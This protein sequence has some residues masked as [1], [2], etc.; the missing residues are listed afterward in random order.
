MYLID[1]VEGSQNL[2]II[3]DESNK[4]YF[5]NALPKIKVR[6][7]GR[8]KRAIGKASV[9]YVKS[10]FGVKPEINITSLA[11]SMSKAFDLNYNDVVAVMLHEMA[12]IQL[13]LNNNLGKHHGTSMFDGLIR[14]LRK[15]SGINVPMKES[16][17]KTSPKAVAM[18]GYL[19]IVHA[20]GGIGIS[21]YSTPFIKKNWRQLGQ[22]LERFIPSG[23][24]RKMELWKVKH[25]VIKNST[26]KRSLKRISWNTVT[27]DELESI[28][29]SGFQWASYGA[30]KNYIN[31][32][33]A[34]L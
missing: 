34:G 9:K 30:G 2:R 13:Y 32:K 26:K 5:G 28:K 27:T 19:A 11:I 17:F 7:D 1:G 18:E 25:Q 6:W 16:T 4:K 20:G 8:L 14:R 29:K 15:E 24:V 10:G 22:F 31:G 3:Y 23:K 21:V 33:K 12:H